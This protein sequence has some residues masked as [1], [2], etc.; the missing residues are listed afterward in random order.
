VRRIAVTLGASAGGAARIII[1]IF[2]FFLFVHEVQEI[3][4]RHAVPRVCAQRP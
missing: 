2:F 3:A 1:I 4:E